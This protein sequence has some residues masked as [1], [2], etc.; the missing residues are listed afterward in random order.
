MRFQQLTGPIMAKGVEDTAFYVYNRLVSLNEVGGMPERFG[1]PLETFHGQNIERRKF[2]PHAL[3]ATATHD[4]KRSEDVRARINVL[5]EMPREWGEHIRMW[6]R[7]NKKKKRVL[8]GREVPD[9]NEEYLLYQTLV[10]IWPLEAPEGGAR[11]EL[12]Q[13]IK[14][15]MIKALREAKQNTSWISPNERYE[16]SVLR[17]IDDLLQQ[18]SNNRFLN[19]FLPFQRMISHY[20]MFNSLSQVL[21]KVCAPGVPDFYQGTEL[22]DFSLVDPDNRRPVDFLQRMELLKRIRAAEASTTGV[23]LAM[24]LTL[25][26][27]D[28]RIKLYVM[29]KALNFRNSRRA[30]FQDGEYRPLAGS[31]TRAEN[32]CAFERFGEGRSAV[33]AVPRLL[34]RMLSGTGA[35]PFG[36]AVWEN[37]RLLLEGDSAPG[38]Q[39]CN[40]FTSEV[41]ETQADGSLLAADVFSSF[42]VALLERLT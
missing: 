29:G 21:L 4:T 37:T 30:L 35:V 18:R 7:L 13:R 10:G 11:E 38:R 14:N 6:A 5:S 33:V 24:D 36:K 25:A 42:P 27:D 22:W 1:T 8:E 23:A 17:F 3:I 39:Y 9:R 40:I 15:Y 2:W 34:T 41:I 19:D 28:G 26:K 20:G 16:E 32:L 12:L 31:G